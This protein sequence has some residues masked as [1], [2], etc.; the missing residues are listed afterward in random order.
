MK[1]LAIG[2]AIL[3]VLLFRGTYQHFAPRA[4]VPAV[5]IL[6]PAPVRGVC[7]WIPE[8]VGCPGARK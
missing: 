7:D 5:E 3:A 4:K 8:H 2:G 6:D 1:P